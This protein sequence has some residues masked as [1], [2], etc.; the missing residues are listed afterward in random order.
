MVQKFPFVWKE[1]GYKKL[2]ASSGST[3]GMDKTPTQDEYENALKGGTDLNKKIVKLVELNE[4]ACEDF[5]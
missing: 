5:I 2:L 1:K 4:L 3:S